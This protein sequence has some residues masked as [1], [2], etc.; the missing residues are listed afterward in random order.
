MD[1]KSDVKSIMARF[2]AGG[3]ATEGISTERPK[4]A[5]H[6]TLSSGP[7]I[8]P[9]KPALEIS[10]S[11]SAASTAPKPKFLKSTISTLSAPEVRD[12]HR[13]KAIPSKFGNAQED[14][15]PSV[16]KQYPV[17]LKPPGPEIS[18]DAE[19]KS[20]PPK[21]PL[22]KPSLSLT[23]SDAKPAFPKPP[24]GVAKPSWVKDSSPKPDDSGGTPNSI[25]PKIPPS[26]KNISS[27]VKM[28]PQTEDNVAGAVD[29][30]IK[31]FGG[32]STLKPSNFRTAQNVFNR[33]ETLSENGV[34]EIAKLPLTSSDSCLTK[35][36]DSRKPSFIKKPL[37]PTSPVVGVSNSS[38]STPK[39]NPLPNILALGTAPVKPNRPP[40]VNL[41][42]FKKG[43]EASADS[44]AGL[45]KGS[46]PPP[47]A[48][49]PS[50]HMA[51]PLPSHPMAPSLPP[52]PP[53]AII[54]P[55]PDENYD[56]VG[57]MNN[58]PPPPSGGHPS[59]M[60]KDSESDEEM[61][62]DLD[63]RWGTVESKEQEKKREREEKKRQEVEKKEQKERE[64]KEQEARKKFKLTG[65]L[66]VIH[67]VQARVDSKG[68]KTDL[69]L[70]QGESI[71]I[72]RV[73]DNPE[74]RWLGRSQDGSYGYVKTESVQI[75]FDTL[76][77]QGVSISSHME[78][79]PEVYDDVDFR[80]DLSS[81]I[82]GPGVVLPPPPEKD[83]DIYDDLDDSSF[84]VSPSP[85]DSR[86]PPKPRS[87][88]FKG[89]EEWRKSPGSKIEVPPPSQ[90]DQAG[91]TEQSSEV[92]DTEI[93]DD[94]DATNFH[95]PP[96]ISS[97]SQSKTKGK[98]ED[99]DPKKIKKFEKEEKEFRKKF[100]YDGEI[101]V[102]YQVTIVSTLANK[103][104]SSKDLPLRPGETL[105]V[106][107]KPV[108]N[109]LI[110]RNEEGKFGYVL[111]SHIVVEDAD[112]Y[113]DIGD[114]CV[115]DN[116]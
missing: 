93:Y 43:T 111:T 113:D 27:I 36:I 56:D 80:N 74:G 12:L 39:R 3:N 86:S 58:P 65:P 72:M 35:P 38:P 84:D 22:Q 50:N 57:L 15:K 9:K 96:P 99:K 82:K 59:Q 64:R 97:L 110:C 1:N 44:P 78:H 33:G 103:K 67:R 95:P 75:D 11:G 89:F 5:V 79:E 77:R 85:S 112:I 2:N 102:L 76:K 30:T 62:E 41:E 66:E 32:A 20:P 101:Q 105:D 42:K 26:K 70:K 88:M 87:W 91:N 13:I 104:W 100:K 8:Q 37:G 116:D 61:Y 34:K 90:F 47:P 94:V 115:Y 45:R 52:R 81:G 55:D 23:L 6:P 24:L 63:E 68:S 53:E 40:T 107:V 29:S 28:R 31:P 25:P 109:K 19:V 51:P 10:L 16:V 4:P 114:D 106:I 49:H 92:S 18:Q 21:L 108:D 14:S 54:Q 73:L 98:V 71:E 17:K 46:V 69:G 83:G 48:S 60:T 7:P